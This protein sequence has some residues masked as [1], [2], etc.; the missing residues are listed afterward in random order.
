MSLRT[1]AKRFRAGMGAYMLSGLCLAAAHGAMAA[2]PSADWPSFFGN[3]QA[4]SYSPLDQI[5]TGNVKHLSV[6]WAFSTG[7]KGLGA[8][9]L[10]VDG[11]MYL[12][13]PSNKLFAIDAATGK[14][15]L[16]LFARGAAGTAGRAGRRDP[17]SPWASGLSSSARSTIIM[18]AV[19]AKTGHEVWDT[20]IEDYR[21]CKCTTSFTPLVA[22]DKVVIGARGDI[23]HR[24]YITAYDA[25]TG[26]QAWRF[27]AIPGKGEPGNDSWQGDQ[28]ELGGGSTWFGGSYDAKLNLVYW[29][30]GN[31]QPMLN[32]KARP[33]NNLYTGSLVALDADTGKLKWYF[34]ENPN[35]SLD[36][37]AIPEPVLVDIKHNGKIEPLLL[38]PNKSGYD[39][40]AEPRDRQ[41]HRRLVACRSAELDEGAGQ[42]R[43]PIDPVQTEVG[44][45]KLI[46]PSLYGSRAGNHSTYSPQD[47]LVV[48]YLLR[49]LRLYQGNPADAGQGGRHVH[50]RL[51]PPGALDDHQA[52]HRRVRPADRPTQ[53][54]PY[55]RRTDRLGADLDR[56]RPD[57]RRRPVRHRLGAGRQDR[58]DLV[59]LLDRRRHFLLTDQLFGRRQAICRDRHRHDGRAGHAGR[60]ALAGVQGQ[61][62]RRSGSTLFVF[63]LPHGG[64]GAADAH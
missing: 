42:G 55:D 21:Q 18:V 52:V 38:H 44:I 34:Q 48:Q 57:L 22:G 62:C 7:E 6:A 64:K 19:D 33:G 9:P 39:L 30:V 23:A 49:G 8:T 36:Y 35:D 29:G 24:A 47:R 13:A 27:W 2:A 14:P 15:A 3:D 32:A 56:R 1:L 40:C 16:D 26:K 54:D 45:D 58:Q 37:D 43:H 59:V 53:M 28:W 51:H 25:K 5:N 11:T 17:A 10:V 50:G 46:C 20:Q 12:V 61:A 63:A 4:W 41:V 31:P 60:A